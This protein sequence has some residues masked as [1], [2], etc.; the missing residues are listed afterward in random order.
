MITMLRKEYFWPNMK[1]E[2]AEFLARCIECQQVKAEHQNPPDL[3]QSLPI[4]NWKWEVI[5]LD[6]VTGLPKNQKQNYSIMVVVDKLSKE[7]HFIPIKTTYKDANI[8]DIFM[9]MILSFAWNS[10]G[11]NF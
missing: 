7:T 11:N 3:L 10:K 4:P 5:S 1:N 9:K 8:A 2:V 6:F